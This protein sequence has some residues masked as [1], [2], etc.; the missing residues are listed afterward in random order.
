MD[1][2][3]EAQ[4]QMFSTRAALHTPLFLPGAVDFWRR[5]GFTLTDIEHDPVWHT[6]HMERRLLRST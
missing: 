1:F 5:Q 2:V 3:T 6:T 4:A